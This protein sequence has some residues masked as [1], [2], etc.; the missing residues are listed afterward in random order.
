[1]FIAFGILSILAGILAFRQGT[2][3]GMLAKFAQSSQGSTV[4][5]G[6]SAVAIAMI[7]A[8][9][10]CCACKSGEKRGMVK[11]AVVAYILGGIFALAVSIGDTV[12]YGVGCAII[13]VILIIWLRNH[14]YA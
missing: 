11:A 12:I 4:A 14:R 2:A 7:V 9:I 10:L 1:M 3:L 13:A 8:G 5:G 6:F